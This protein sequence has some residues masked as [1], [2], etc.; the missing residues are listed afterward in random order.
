[1]SP[2]WLWDISG[3]GLGH[4]ST[5]SSLP[6]DARFDD[7]YHNNDLGTIFNGRSVGL[8][9]NCFSDEMLDGTECWSSDHFRPV[10]AISQEYI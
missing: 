2:E 5:L 4:I 3:W 6:T 10:F 9:T 1:M 8:Q 7:D